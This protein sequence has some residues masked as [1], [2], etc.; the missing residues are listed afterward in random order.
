MLN[1]VTHSKHSISH[2]IYTWFCCALFCCG[3]ISSV[4]RTDAICL[5]IFFRV[6]SLAQGHICPCASEV[7]LKPMGKDDRHTPT[8]PKKT[9]QNKKTQQSKN[10][11]DVYIWWE[12]WFIGCCWSN[13][14]NMISGLAP[15]WV[16]V[17]TWTND[18]HSN[19]M[20]LFELFIW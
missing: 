17:T 5:P 19:R 4:Q 20:I 7:T 10:M 9:K 18:D 1:Q 13:G 16:Q 14:C 6:T 11:N 12:I 3:Y 15:N 2:R 8:P